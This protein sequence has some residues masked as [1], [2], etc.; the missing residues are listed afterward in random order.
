[1]KELLI[2]LGGLCV[3]CVFLLR[4]GKRFAAPVRKEMPQPSSVAEILQMTT[5]NNTY[6]PLFDVLSGL[7]S[8]LGKKGIALHADMKGYMGN[9][10]K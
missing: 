10:K 8:N 3:S 6:P 7:Q 2:C 9:E 4:E 1:M 5:T